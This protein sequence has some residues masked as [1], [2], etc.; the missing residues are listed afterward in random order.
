MDI[1][2][3][4]DESVMFDVEAGFPEENVNYHRDKK[5]GEKLSKG[6]K[7]WSTPDNTTFLPSHQTAQT[8]VPGLYLIE[9]SPSVGIFFNK[10]TVVSSELIRFEDGLINEVVNECS[11]FWDNKIKYEKLGLLHKRGY[12]FFGPPGSGKSSLINMIMSD[13]IDRGGVCFSFDN[14]PD[15]MRD[16][17]KVFRAIQPNT[18]AVIIMEDI[19]GLV[20]R[21]GPSNILNILDGV[22]QISGVIFVATT[23]YIGELESRF[24]NRPS[25]FD[26]RILVGMPTEG[27][28][29]RYINSL[30]SKSDYKFSE[31]EIEGIVADTKDF[32]MAHIKELLISIMVFGYKY[33]DVLR[34][35][36]DMRKKPKEDYEDGLS[37]ESIG[38][39]E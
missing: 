26:R 35:L 31:K 32:S 21:Y 37:K 13:V 9:K 29:R 6:H 28:R 33:Q 15:I 10:Q 18:P 34:N 25:R 38:F 1:G 27:V 30:A 39:S 5:D 14:S 23:N 16:G 24:S 19:D 11:A 22:D 20:K 3:S 12:M 36:K 8:L 7:M 17:L 4:F 2:D